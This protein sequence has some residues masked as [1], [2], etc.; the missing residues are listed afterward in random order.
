MDTE[1]VRNP[2]VG[3]VHTN[4]DPQELS[5]W[6]GVEECHRPYITRAKTCSEVMPVKV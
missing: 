4:A 2:P 6:V 5:L 3:C 1:E